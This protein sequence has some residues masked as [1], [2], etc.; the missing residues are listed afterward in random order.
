MLG[1]GVEGSWF[2]VMWLVEFG[3]Y[4]GKLGVGDN[5]IYEVKIF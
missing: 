1:L 5:G 4:V 2:N 3:I